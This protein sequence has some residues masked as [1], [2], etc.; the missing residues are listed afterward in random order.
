[1]AFPRHEPIIRPQPVHP[2]GAR[3]DDVLLLGVGIELTVSDFEEA[4]VAQRRPDSHSNAMERL[5]DAR[6]GDDPFTVQSRAQGFG[7][8]LRRR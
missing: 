2:R 3:P 1:M 6:A 5:V 8:V 7:R 4:G